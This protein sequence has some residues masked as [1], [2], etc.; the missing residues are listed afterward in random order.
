MTVKAKPKPRKK[1]RILAVKWGLNP[2]SSSLGVDVTFLLF[3][4]AFVSLLTPIVGA[5]VR[6]RRASSSS[7][8]S[9]SSGAP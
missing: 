2:N 1:G 4:A 8:S 3:G 6:W 9:A 7:S 5:L